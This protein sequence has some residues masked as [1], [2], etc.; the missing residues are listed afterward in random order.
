MF[1][2]FQQIIYKLNY[3][4][5]SNNCIIAQPLDI[6]VGAGTFH[7]STFF[8]AIDYHQW[9][10][11]FVQ[12]CRRPSDGRKGN[13]PN[14]Q[15]QFFQY[16]VVLK[17][18]PYNLQELYLKSL[19]SLGINCL[20]NDI[21]FVEDNWEGPTLGANGIGWEV[22]LNGM[23]IS[24]FT[25]FQQMGGFKCYPVMGELAYGIERI[26]L[27]IQN[28]KNI[29]D[30]IWYSNEIEMITYGDIFKQIEKE[31]N[32]YNFY[33]ADTNYLVKMFN[34]IEDEIINIIK[35]GLPFPAYELVLKA[36]HLFNLI[37]ARGVLSIT[38]RQF[39]ILR[40]RKYAFKIAHL[41]IEKNS[42]K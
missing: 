24:Q 33:I 19:T 21:R 34:L 36:S 39:F 25:Y 5:E 1:K 26:A 41:Y 2:D 37:N 35:N 3:F 18:C 14:R 17:P 38:E 13:H 8:K 32:L 10:C 28:K 4:W 40:I 20:E 22:W 29:Q 16:Q 6:E 27:Y 9:R 30:I 7:P 12:C 42:K 11:A 15:Q 31:M 23:E